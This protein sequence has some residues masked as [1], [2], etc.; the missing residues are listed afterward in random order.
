MSGFVT[1]FLGARFRAEFYDGIVKPGTQIRPLNSGD[2]YEWKSLLEAI[3]T[4]GRRFVM[5]DLGAGYGWWGINAAAALKARHP[6]KRGLI[7]MVEAEPTHYRWLKT[8]IADNPYP[9][10][11]YRPVEAAIGVRQGQDWFYVGKSGEWYGQRLML[12]YHRKLL[13]E[14]RENDVF[15]DGNGLATSDGYRLNQVSIVTLQNLLPRFSSVDLIDMD[16]QG[17]EADLIEAERGLLARRVKRLFISTHSAEID[18]RV[19]AALRGDWDL[20]FGF[21]PGS[22]HETEHGQIAFED[23]HQFWTRV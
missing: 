5:I 14:N 23:G 7:V 6:R 4:C 10:V 13:N 18:E 1:S 11:R 3:D 22:V 8:A 15:A 12:D 19:R 17:T 9:S 20:R 16:I 2:H 21:E